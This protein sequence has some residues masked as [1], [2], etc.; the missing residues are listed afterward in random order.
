LIDD[1]PLWINSANLDVTNNGTYS[2]H[3]T[4]STYEPMDLKYVSSIVASHPFVSQV[5]MTARRRVAVVEFS[6]R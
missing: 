1:S 6:E 5:V 2:P 3:S 4:T